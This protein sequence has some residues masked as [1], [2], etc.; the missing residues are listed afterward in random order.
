[1]ISNL[2]S[3]PL[4]MTSL[5]QSIFFLFHNLSGKGRLGDLIIIFLGDYF[6]YV[7]LVVFLYNVFR[8]YNKKGLSNLWPY[9]I[10]LIATGVAEY[11][12]SSVKV[13][14]RSPR[15]FLELELQHLIIDD[16][17]SFP[18]GHTTF[19]F[20]LATATY[21]FNK[22][23]AYF[24]YTSGV[25]VGLARIAGGAHYPSDILNGAILG[26]IIGY[27]I[28]KLFAYSRKQTYE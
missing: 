26:A 17:F 3:F 11:L 15:P 28:Y 19:L 12:S 13:F 14:V 9:T 27:L 10:A 18:S 2:D 5:D 8:T 1:M 4:T 23:L 25:L 16:T 24:L 22:K 6:L 21:F 20:S 7:A